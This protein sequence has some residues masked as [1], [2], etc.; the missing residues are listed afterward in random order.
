MSIEQK[1][2]DTQNNSLTIY[3]K[4]KTWTTVKENIGE[5]QPWGR[6]RSFIG[7]KEEEE[8]EN[9]EHN[10]VSYMHE[11]ELKWKSYFWTTGRQKQRLAAAGSCEHYP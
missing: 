9:L 3:R 8:E 11:A 7:Q 2:L 6:N 4:T 5:T 10:E 1:T